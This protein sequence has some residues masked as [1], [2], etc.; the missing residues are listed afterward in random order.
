MILHEYIVTLDKFEDLE[1]FYTDMEEPGGN[2]Y[3]PNRQVKCSNRRSMSRNTHYMLTDEEA[4]I[5]KQ[6]TRVIDVMRSDI[7]LAGTK[8]SYIQSANF[9]KSG[10]N[11]SSHVNWGLIRCI[12]GVHQANWGSNNITSRNASIEF[13]YTGKN[14]DVIII[15]G[16]IDPSH[17]ELQKNADGSGGSRVVQLNWHQYTNQADVIDN[18]NQALLTGNYVYTPY[19]GSTAVTD[20]NNHGIHVAGTACGSTQ[21]WARDA[22]I[23]NIN[24]YSTNPNTL[25]S[26]I[27]WDYIRAFHRNKPVNPLT[28]RKNPTICN[29]SYGVSLNFPYAYD[30]F[31]TGPIVYINYRGSNIGVS[32][33]T[34]ALS[35]AE[36]TSGGIRISGSIATVPIYV[37]SVAADIQ[38][39][40]SDGIHIVGAAGNEYSKIDVSTGQD[41]NNYFYEYEGGTHYGP[42]YQHRGTAPGSVLGVVCVGSVDNLDNEVKAGYSNCG[43]RID[44]YAPGTGINSSLHTTGVTDPRNASY[45]LGKKQGTSMASPQVC[46]LLACILEVNPNLTP[47]QGLEYIKN[48]A[49]LSQLTDNLPANQTNI[50]SLQGSTNRY[51]FAKTFRNTQGTSYPSTT[52]FL[53]P[54][55]GQ[56]YPRTKRRR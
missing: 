28:G 13:P 38:D 15:D 53:R 10:S 19:I 33:S 43:P 55:T 46:G 44:V 25:S 26:L 47:T 56:A 6:D 5:L 8:P 37:A 48:V 20:N 36:I 18:D 50:Q 39:A 45:T 41:Y 23:Y 2:L 30:G 31:N 17:P 24:P 54:T 35:D 22:N 52:N 32:T 14:V 1:S 27:I 3:I 16:H 4:D 40:I 7:I 9:S 34:V 12:E 51:L 29:G 21:G 11:S 42:Y 49:K